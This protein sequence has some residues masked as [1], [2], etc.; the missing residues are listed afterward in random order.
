MADAFHTSLNTIQEAE[1]PPRNPNHTTEES[2]AASKKLFYSLEIIK[3]KE[4]TEN[5]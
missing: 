3:G 5:T 4:D 1:R 2:F